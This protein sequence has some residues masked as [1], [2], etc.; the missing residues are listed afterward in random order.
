MQSPEP[1][2]FLA[3]VNALVILPMKMGSFPPVNYYASRNLMGIQLCS[4]ILHPMNQS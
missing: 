1:S 4:M 2:M 3:E